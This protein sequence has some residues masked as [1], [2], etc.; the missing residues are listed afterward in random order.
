MVSD[1]HFSVCLYIFG[2]SLSA[3]SDVLYSIPGQ[4]FWKFASLLTA[5]LLYIY[6]L[7]H[8]RFHVCATI[9]WLIHWHIELAAPCS[10]WRQ[11][12]PPRDRDQNISRK[13]TTTHIRPYTDY[14][15]GVPDIL[16]CPVNYGRQCQI[17]CP[18]VNWH[19]VAITSAFLRHHRSLCTLRSYDCASLGKHSFRSHLRFRDVE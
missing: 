3:Q 10:Q 16:I 2:E 15:D 5:L 4:M 11:L 19:C 13:N 14:T 6:C 17:I 1:N 7:C 9:V 8:C 12:V 18:Y